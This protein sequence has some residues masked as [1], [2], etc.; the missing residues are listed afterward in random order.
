MLKIADVSLV[1]G[2]RKIK[3]GKSYSSWQIIYTELSFVPHTVV[4]G[5][6]AGTSFPQLAFT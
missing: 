5:G 4:V 6:V 1:G 3:G 2:R